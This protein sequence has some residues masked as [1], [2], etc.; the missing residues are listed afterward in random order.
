MRNILILFLCLNISIPLSFGQR[1]DNLSSFRDVPST[2]YLRFNYDND[3]FVG[4][5]QNYTQGFS[6]EYVSPFLKKNPINYLFFKPKNTETRYGLA[7]EHN[8][9]TPDRYFVPEIQLGDRPF[10][11][12]LMLKSFVISTDTIKA[13][14]FTSSF[15]IGMIGQAALGEEIQIGIHKVT[16][17]ETPLG[18][19]NQIQNDVV[20]N[21]GFGYEKQLVRFRDFFSIQANANGKLGTLFT[22]GSVGINATIGILNSPFSSIKSKNNFNF[23]VF[24]QPLINIIGYDATL[25]GGV[26]DR[27]SPYSI[28][29][30]DIERFT[31]QFNYGIVLRIK[32]F[33]LE[34]SGALITREFKTGGSAKWGGVKIGVML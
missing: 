19:P 2:Q 9:F 24:A 8:S 13:S 33:Y 30:V 26:F 27:K 23:Y 6:L 14:R 25:Q 18:W 11:A 20:L 22:N 4:T 16:D 21:Y 7:I 34:Y 15:I 31:G 28:S 32:T 3:L 5:D 12:A 29:S 17:S 10:S 1:I